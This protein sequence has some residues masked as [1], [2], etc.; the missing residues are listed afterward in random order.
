M[1]IGYVGPEAAVGGPIAWLKDGDVVAIDAV[2]G[3]LS[4]QLADAE[5]SARR[6]AWRPASRKP[7]AGALEK[8]EKLVGP[9][10]S[11][12]VTHSGA[13]EWPYET[14]EP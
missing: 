2:A 13:L 1:C 3:T 14:G 7:L 12:A 8:Y 11:G 9:A 6:A 10:S 5:L 4:V